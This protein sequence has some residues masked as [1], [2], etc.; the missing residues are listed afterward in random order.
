MGPGLDASPLTDLLPQLEIF[1]ATDD[2]QMLERIRGAEYVFGNKVLLDD[3]LFDQVQTLRF[4]GLTA[5]GTDNID[6][7]GAAR[8]GIAV[9]NIRGY[10]TQSVTEHVFALLLSLCRSLPAHLADVRDGRWQ[11][12]VDFCVLSR[13]IVELSTLT[14]GIVGLGELGRSVASTA[15]HFGMDVIVAAR[16]NQAIVPEG[17]LGFEQFLNQADVISLHCPLT[18][19]TRNL[20]GAAEFAAMKPSA[21][22]IN[23]ARGGLVDSAALADALA[24]GGIA[25]AAV[26]VLPTEP[27]T[28][29]DPLL[30]YAGDNLLITP[31]IAWA[32]DRARQ[33]AIAELARNVAAF[34]QGEKRNRVV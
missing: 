24:N 7:D 15:R 31:H 8:R 32:S 4:I 25:A 33:E 12:S 10:C 3:Q 13:P 2:D 30:D 5:T 18:D 17:R 14:M 1:D 26:D 29:G 19:T 20:F 22:L 6:L 27:P 16:P 9:C 28:D 34:M 23:T 11:E 21:M